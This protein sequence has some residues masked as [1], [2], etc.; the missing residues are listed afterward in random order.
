MVFRACSSGVNAIA[1]LSQHSPMGSSRFVQSYSTFPL[2]VNVKTIQGENVC[3]YG[4]AT[5]GGVEGSSDQYAVRCQY[6]G[7]VSLTISHPFEAVASSG[8]KGTVGILT[9]ISE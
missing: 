8:L 6:C 9:L 5:V 2:T 3:G 4:T 7:N 1:N